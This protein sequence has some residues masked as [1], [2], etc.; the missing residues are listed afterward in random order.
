MSTTPQQVE[1]KPPPPK[2]TERVTIPRDDV[3]IESIKRTLYNALDK[4]DR[5]KSG[6]K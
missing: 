4:L 6:K 1:R 3:E 5:L 2:E